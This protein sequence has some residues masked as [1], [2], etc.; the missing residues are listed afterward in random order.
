MAALKHFGTECACCGETEIWFL[1]IDHKNVDGK[2]HREEMN[3]RNIYEWLKNNDYKCDFELR[4]LC[5]NCNYGSYR[6]GG[7]CPH[8]R[9][10][11]SET[12]RKT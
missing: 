6:T 2:K 11:G 5:Y 1:T 10:E 9:S 8:E 12:S 7:A 4:T 3:H